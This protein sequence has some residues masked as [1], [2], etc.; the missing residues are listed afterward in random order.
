[1]PQ[2]VTMH[3]TFYDDLPTLTYY[4]GAVPSWKHYDPERLP[5]PIQDWLNMHFP[6]I[7]IERV[8]DSELPEFIYTVD[9][10]GVVGTFKCS[11]D[12]PHPLFRVG[13]TADQAEVFRQAWTQPPLKCPDGEDDF[14]LLE[15]EDYGN[16]NDETGV[17]AELIANGD[18]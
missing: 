12:L 11:A 17:E 14:Y 6:G 7:A 9:S 16:D 2:I 1:M 10:D 8:S 13:F 4:I 3:E 18:Q 15:Y 5:L